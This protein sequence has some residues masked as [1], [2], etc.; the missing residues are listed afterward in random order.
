MTPETNMMP[1]TKT[2][3]SDHQEQ[4]DDE[5]EETRSTGCCGILSRKPVL[6]ILVFAAVETIERINGTCLKNYI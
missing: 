1:E 5:E 2:F 4:D 6:S 3:P